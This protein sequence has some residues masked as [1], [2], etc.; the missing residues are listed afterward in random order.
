MGR[1]GRLP[2]SRRD[3]GATESNGSYVEL[4]V[5]SSKTLVEKSRNDY[6]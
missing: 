1:A 4:V 2:D 3:A 6:H 5:S